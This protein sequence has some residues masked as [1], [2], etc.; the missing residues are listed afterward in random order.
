MFRSFRYRNYRL[1]FSGQSLS[2]IGTW[3]QQI[4]IPWLVYRLTGSPVWL[5]VV[6]FCTQ[7]PAF[8]LAP[9]AGVMID[10]WNR[11][12]VL[13]AT[14][15]C[16]MIQAFALA[17]LYYTHVIRIWQ[18]VAL[19]IFLGIVNAFDMPARQSL[20]IKLVEK[21]EDLGNAIALNS[22][23]VNLARLLGPSIA[24]VLIA[25][26]NEGFCFLCNGIS[27]FFVIISL[28]MMNFSFERA[29]KTKAH[30]LQEFKMGFSYVFGFIPF[31]YVILL[32][33]LV[34][35]MGSPYAVLMPVFARE[36]LHGGSYTFGFI[37]GSSGVGALIGAFY[38]ASR[39]TVSGL[40]KVIPVA[41]LVFGAGL[42]AFSFSRIM[43]LCC[44]LMFVVGFGMTVGMASS[45][46]L[47]QTLADDDKRGRVMSF[48]TMAFI[49]SVPIGSLFS[50]IMAEHIG[51]PGA[52]L[53]GG[54]ACIL[55]AIVYILNLPKLKKMVLPFYRRMGMID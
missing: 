46:T 15:V 34:S 25:L 23:M 13:V 47:I 44:L 37:M 39:K 10:R 4:A 55:G 33:A 8:L 18:I 51:A 30:V 5:G 40:E 1:F 27:F 7:I 41:A 49:G 16:A 26:T 19:G 3:I 42:V 38:L 22:T 17:L 35:L 11:Y 14:Q 21:R 45:N 6:G 32:L 28:L 31:R 52:L 43:T 29:P 24:G 20:V 36:V 12:R 50:G 54:V 9:Y 2:L 48:Y 53:T